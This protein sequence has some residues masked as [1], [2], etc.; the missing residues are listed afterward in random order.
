MTEPL[1][2]AI[3]RRVKQ[4]R[5]ARGVSVAELARRMGVAHRSLWK[6]EQGQTEDPGISKVLAAAQALDVP[7]AALLDEEAFKQAL[8][9]VLSARYG[10]G[11]EGGGDGA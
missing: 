6:L 11:L 5:E 8:A 10:V 9:R 4:L 2:Q 3:G 7:L 1:G